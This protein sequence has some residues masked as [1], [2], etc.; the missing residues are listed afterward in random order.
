MVD[1]APQAAAV[2]GAT[3]ESDDAPTEE[4]SD[5]EEEAEPP[6]GGGARKDRNRCDSGCYCCGRKRG[7]RFRPWR[8][9]MHASEI[10]KTKKPASPTSNF[11]CGSCYQHAARAW[12]KV[13][14]QVRPTIRYFSLV[15]TTSM[16]NSRGCMWHYLHRHR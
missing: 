6:D 13:D 9:S 3:L 2:A 5:V 16:S 8:A 14:H 10:E 4:E 1:P 15:A 11:I 12:T 7:R